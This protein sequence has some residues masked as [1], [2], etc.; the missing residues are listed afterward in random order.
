[1]IRV[2][3]VDLPAQ[4]ASL[5]ERLLAA[6]ETVLEHGQFILGPEV[7]KLEERLAASLGAHAVVGVNSGT[8]ALAM[9]L[10]LRGVGP[11]DEVITVSHSFVATAT[12][13]RLV[14]AT[15]VFVD[16]DPETMQID[17]GLLAAARTPRTR[18]VLPVHLNGFPCPIEEVATFC[19][20]NELVLIEDCAQA[21][22][23]RRRRRAVGTFGVGCF[24]LHPLKVLS[25][26]GDAGFLAVGSE[27]DAEQLRRMRNIGLRDRDHCEIVSGNSRLDTLQAAILLVKLEELPRWLAVRRQHAAAYRGALAGRVRLPPEE[28]ED[29]VVYSAFVVRHPQ[30]DRLLG[31]LAEAGVAA[32]IHYPIPIHRQQAFADLPL[33]FPLPVTERVVAEMMSLP[34]TPEMSSEQREIVVEALLAA[35]D[36]V[37]AGGD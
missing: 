2:P 22:G 8:D 34:V 28:G 29:E 20:E 18:A 6:V 37:E 35:L 13:V 11:G 36:R 4:A 33:R 10:R 3:Y 27:E 5:R 1:M 9:A 21:F 12:A 7:V 24:S 16:V 32:K 25:A 15:P 30:R 31:A 19:E 23:A 14:G 26:C 17:P